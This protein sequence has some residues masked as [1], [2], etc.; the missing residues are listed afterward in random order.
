[1]VREVIKYEG[2]FILSVPRFGAEPYLGRNLHDFVHSERN[3][4]S[5]FKAAEPFNVDFLNKKYFEQAKKLEEEFQK[6]SEEM[7]KK[8]EE[9]DVKE[10]KE[11]II[12]RATILSR[13]KIIRK[14]TKLIDDNE[15]K[16]P[17]YFEYDIRRNFGLIYVASPPRLGKSKPVNLEK[18][19]L[20]LSKRDICIS[21]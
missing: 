4:D 11:E 21:I 2:R 7:K 15:L 16:E 6:A 17:V 20:E 12:K 5:V 14:D 1:M 18:I 3:M 8:A 13:F 9:T 10:A 19:L